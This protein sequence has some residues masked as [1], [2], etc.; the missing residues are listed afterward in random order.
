[1]KHRIAFTVTYA[2][3]FDEGLIFLRELGGLG[4]ILKLD[5]A[6]ERLG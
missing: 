6:G 5:I 3:T 4:G 1:M 2:E